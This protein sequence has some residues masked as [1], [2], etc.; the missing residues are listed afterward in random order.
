MTIETILV[1][2]ALKYD[3]ISKYYT[4]SVLIGCDFATPVC[5]CYRIIILAYYLSKHFAISRLTVVA[6]YYTNHGVDF[7]I[8]IVCTIMCPSGRIIRDSNV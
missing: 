5:F 1:S 6:V 7:V 8:R 4:V 3:P 2:D